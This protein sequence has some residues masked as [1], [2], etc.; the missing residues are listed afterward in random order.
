MVSVSR[1]DRNLSRIP[2]FARE[3]SD[4]TGAGD[5]VVAVL[6]LM[7]VMGYPLSRCIQ[8]ANAAAGIVVGHIGAASVTPPELRSELERLTE[9]G[10]IKA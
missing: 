5:T 6:S 1:D 7:M 10:L 2:T 4:V 3:V 8:I 9:S